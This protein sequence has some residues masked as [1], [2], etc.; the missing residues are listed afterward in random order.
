MYF[1]EAE[2]A[3]YKEE[4]AKTIEDNRAKNLEEKSN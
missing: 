4:L 2:E 1:D 3:A